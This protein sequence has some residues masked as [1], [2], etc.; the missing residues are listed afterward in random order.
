VFDI[1]SPFPFQ[2]HLLIPTEDMAATEAELHLRFATKRLRGEWFSLTPED[3]ALI[4]Q[5]YPTVDHHR[6][7]VG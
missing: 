3:L 4:A 7:S 1:Q 2:V 5:D 6:L